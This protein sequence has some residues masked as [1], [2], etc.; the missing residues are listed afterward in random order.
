MLLTH[1][2]AFLDSPAIRTATG[3]VH[4]NAANVPLWTDDFAS[5]FQILK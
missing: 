2:K 4:T 1:N 5:L 3:L